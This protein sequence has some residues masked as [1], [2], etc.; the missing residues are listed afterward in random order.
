MRTGTPSQDVSI[1]IAQGSSSSA[2][3]K[4]IDL[5]VSDCE[6]PEP[7]G[8]DKDADGYGHGSPCTFP[9]GFL[10]D[11]VTPQVLREAAHAFEPCHE[12]ALDSDEFLHLVRGL[13]ASLSRP[14]DTLPACEASH[15]DLVRVERL[16]AREREVLTHVVAGNPNKLT[17]AALNISRR[18]V[19]H[20]RAAIMQKTRARSVSELVMLALRTGLCNAN[21]D[22][23][24]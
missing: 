20:H 23:L 6:S 7:Y 24:A 1:P 17:A 8:L 13:I 21:D 2:R 22:Q 14:A 16:T 4:R 3:R 12:A 9:L 15:L 18:T 11:G 5:V 10:E 19:E